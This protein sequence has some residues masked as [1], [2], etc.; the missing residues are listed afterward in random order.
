MT[1][2]EM[3][4]WVVSDHVLV[5]SN[6]D[7]A[8]LRQIADTLRAIGAAPAWLSIPHA[9]T[10]IDVSPRTIKQWIH[11][12]LLPVRHTVGGNPR[13]R[14]ADLLTGTQ[15][16]SPNPKARQASCSTLK[17]TPKRGKL[18]ANY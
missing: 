14:A 5:R 12:G 16:P 2:R 17:R 7:H 18:S 11:R 6:D 3:A 13:V 8:I 9:A 4:A 1:P 10:L 15:R